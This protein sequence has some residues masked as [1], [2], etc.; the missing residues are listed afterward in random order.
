MSVRKWRIVRAIEKG[1]LE[2]ADRLASTPELRRY[3]RALSRVDQVLHA[4][5]SAAR[6][7]SSARP[8]L[9]GRIMESVRESATGRRLG[10]GYARWA[11]DFSSYWQRTVLVLAGAA[12]AAGMIA[13][14]VSIAPPVQRG[15][16]EG[17]PFA[18]GSAE[19]AS[20]VPG[21]AAQRPMVIDPGPLIL[22][23]SRTVA[24]RVDAPLINEAAQLRRE[25]QRAADMVLGA[26]PFARR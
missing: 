15:P 20:Q 17:R 7:M 2:R 9:A 4:E 26:V 18:V 12:G 5:G 10:S 3:I 23:V 21:V 8:E 19:G 6:R 14:I 22:P 11:C 24:E 25:T 1:D 16:V 13:V